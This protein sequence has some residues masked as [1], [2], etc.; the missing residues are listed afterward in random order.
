V[1]QGV[2]CAALASAVMQCPRIRCAPALACSPC[3]LIDQWLARAR[4][5]ERGQVLTISAGRCQSSAPALNGQHA[6]QGA[7]ECRAL[8]NRLGYTA[9][10][11]RGPH[12]TSQYGT[13]RNPR[14][15][16][17]HAS[18]GSH[19]QTRIHLP[20]AHTAVQRGASGCSSACTCAHR[21][22]TPERCSVTNPHTRVG[23]R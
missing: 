18:T 11:A 10:D 13:C 17:E 4:G 2:A 20:R 12:A 9:A 6:C 23:T 16:I 14:A 1:V 8:L 21:L 19:R 22:D 3:I 7:P 15:C 5:A